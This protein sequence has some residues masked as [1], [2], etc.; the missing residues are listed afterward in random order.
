MWRWS[1]DKWIGKDKW[2]HLIGFGILSLI[3]GLWTTI[4]LAVAWEVKDGLMKWEDFGWIGG[5]GFSY[6][7]IIWSVVGIL[8]VQIIKGALV[9]TGSF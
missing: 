1:K 3:T 4:I 9:W 5:D 7:D 8:I 2:E 6:K